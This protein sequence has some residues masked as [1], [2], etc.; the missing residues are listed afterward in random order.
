[1]KSS[2]LALFVATLLCT[3]AGATDD[4]PRNWD[5][6]VLHYR[7]HLELRD[8]TDAIV[9]ETEITVRFVATGIREFAVDLI[10]RDPGVETGMEV[11]GVSHLLLVGR[12]VRIV[13][14]WMRLPRIE[15]KK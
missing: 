5:V 8:D 6:D 14:A 4:Y 1:M 3:P 15:E 11:S 13:F 10:G 12:M 7:F 2:L 9:G